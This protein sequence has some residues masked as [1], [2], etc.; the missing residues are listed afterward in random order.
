MNRSLPISQ[1]LSRMKHMWVILT[2]VSSSICTAQDLALQSTYQHVVAGEYSFDGVVISRDGRRPTLEDTYWTSLFKKG[3]KE[4]APFDYVIKIGRTQPDGTSQEVGS[5][6][7]DKLAQLGA[8]IVHDGQFGPLWFAGFSEQADKVFLWR[9]EG[10]EE[11]EHAN[12][13]TLYT[14]SIKDNRFYGTAA[15]IATHWDP[16]SMHSSKY[17]QPPSL[18]SPSGKYLAVVVWD[19][20]SR[21]ET[22]LQNHIE[23]V[24][25]EWDKISLEG[26]QKDFL[27]SRPDKTLFALTELHWS[28][29]DQLNYEFAQVSGQGHSRLEVKGEGLASASLAAMRKTSRHGV[30]HVADLFAKAHR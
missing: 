17:Q 12:A 14:W 27:S 23:I 24:N 28:S 21:D 15:S 19:D 25:A 22:F 8:G 18:M 6:T 2:L 26:E 11:S 3:K 1:G 7:L 10:R 9:W 29:S 5:I 13:Y 4:K 30:S 16:T 20:P